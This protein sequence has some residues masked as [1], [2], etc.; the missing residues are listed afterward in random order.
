M[1]LQRPLFFMEGFFMITEVS[2]KRSSYIHWE[3][4]RLNYYS[5]HLLHFRVS[6]T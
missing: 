5:T 4:G 1:L 2:S 3:I 6:T